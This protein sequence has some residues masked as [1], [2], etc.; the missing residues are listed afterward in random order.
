M[1]EI[2]YGRH[3]ILE[4]LRAGRVAKRV[5]VAKGVTMEANLEEIFSRAKAQGAAI[6]ETD[7]GRLEDIAHSEH[8]QGVAAYFDARKVMKLAELLEQNTDL[9][10]VLDG[11]QDPQNL[12]AIARVADAA[13][14]DGLVLGKARAAS[15]TGAVAKASAGAV[16]HVNIVEVVNI[17]SALEELKKAGFWCVGLDVSGTQRYDEFDYKGK[18]ALVVGAEGEGLRHLT[19]QRCDALVK[20]PMLGAVESLN[21]ATAAAVLLYEVGRQRG[22]AKGGGE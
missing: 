18:I 3:P 14:A 17:A 5:V 11:I 21:A 9:L 20:L 13:G 16:E 6:E 2:L 7:R 15:V 22:F 12:G 10:V 8:H 4:A 1:P 19:K